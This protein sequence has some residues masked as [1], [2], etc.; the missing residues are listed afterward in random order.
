MKT[1]RGIMRGGVVELLEPAD[2]AEG[3]EV[4]VQVMR[5]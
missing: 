2:L 1:Y 4:E 5:R 3:I